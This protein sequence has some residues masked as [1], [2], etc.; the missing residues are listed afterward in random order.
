MAGT[1]HDWHCLCRQP[2]IAVG[3]LWG[4]GKKTTRFAVN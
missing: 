2:F 4:K 1:S 3:I